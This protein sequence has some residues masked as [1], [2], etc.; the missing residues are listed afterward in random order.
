M[1][2]SSSRGHIVIWH[3]IT[4]EQAGWE[5]EFLSGKFMVRDWLLYFEV[6]SGAVEC[7]LGV[8]FYPHFPMGLAVKLFSSDPDT[9]FPLPLSLTPFALVI[10][11]A[12]PNPTP[13]P[14]FILTLF[15]LVIVE[16]IPTSHP[17][18][19]PASA[20]NSLAYY[21]LSSFLHLLVFLNVCTSTD[22]L[23]FYV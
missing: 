1:D 19:S 18:P 21:F 13:S 14:P 16:A 4:A 6:Y 17:T 11:E 10:V 7:G 5:L 3:R 8:W 9:T 23:R 22:F 15:S 20:H 12:I 2:T